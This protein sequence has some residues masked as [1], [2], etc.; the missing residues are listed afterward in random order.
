M[1]NKKLRAKI[2]ELEDEVED[3]REK[4]DADTSRIYERLSEQ[5]FILNEFSIEDTTKALV[6]LTHK[7]KKIEEFLE[8][9]YVVEP[10][11]KLFIGYKK[12]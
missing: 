9:E 6:E 1:F 2:K 11:E 8:I 7:L 3:L 4:F 5:Q 10:P 12:K